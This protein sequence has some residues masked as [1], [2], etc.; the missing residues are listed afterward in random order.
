MTRIIFYH[1]NKCAGTALMSLF[2]GMVRHNRI[3]RLELFPERS[4]GCYNSDLIDSL[5]RAEFIHDP[6]GCTD[7][8]KLLGNGLNITWQRDP[9]D[10]LLSQI[11]MIAR[12]RDDEVG[13]Q[14]STHSY[15]RDLAR[16]GTE[17]FLNDKRVEA[18]YERFN[19]FTRV[20]Q[21]GCQETRMLWEKPY[22]AGSRALQDLAMTTAIH[23]L[24]KMDFIGTVETFEQDLADLLKILGRPFSLS[25]GLVNVAPGGRGTFSK[26][27]RA[28]VEP[29]VHIDRQIYNAS[30]SMIAQRKA[31]PDYL[32]LM[33]KSEER[34]VQK[35]VGPRVSELIDASEDIFT[36][37]WYACESNG[38]S[39]HRWIGP[40]NIGSVPF[41]VEKIRDL[42][43]RFRIVDARDASNIN[44]LAVRV[45]GVQHAFEM[46]ILPNGDAMVEM[47][48]PAARMDQQ[49]TLL[50]LEIDCGATS[51]PTDP[52]DDRWL[53]LCIAELEVGPSEKYDLGSL[54]A[55][56]VN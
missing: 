17:A 28:L 2:R 19:G 37:S 27:E 49:N 4:H 13:E 12:L 16:A 44:A 48:I 9:A 7:W 18:H 30:L 54:M 34:Y 39:L 35:R 45:D 42:Y 25:H 21:L 43:C 36:G 22:L 46:N 40:Q 55:L 26:A 6:H 51:R 11:K 56:P 50:W 15:L 32:A 20:M 38:A 5:L 41:H 33:E 29:F 31:D 23:N 52:H 24:A 8:K 53:G 1:V 14:G 10:R 3:F 47:I